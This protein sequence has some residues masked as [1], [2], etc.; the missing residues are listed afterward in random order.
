M[1]PTVSHV[2]PGFFPLAP[3]PQDIARTRSL[4][5]TREEFGA[6]HFSTP[7]VSGLGMGPSCC[8]RLGNAQVLVAS[9]FARIEPRVLLS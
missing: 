3:V 6:G 2:G 5:V 7:G 9:V 8:T 1:S 4:A